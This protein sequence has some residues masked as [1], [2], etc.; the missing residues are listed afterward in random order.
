[1]RSSQF[2]WEA[3]VLS[4]IERNSLRA[5]RFHWDEDYKIGNDGGKWTAQALRWEA[6]PLTAH[7]S[8]ELLDKLRDDYAEHAAKRA[9]E[10]GSL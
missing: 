2:L 4:Q 3:A 5:L 7:S 9:A 8:N 1:M 6:D 10:G